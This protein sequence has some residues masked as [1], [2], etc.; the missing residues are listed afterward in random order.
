MRSANAYAANTFIEEPIQGSTEDIPSNETRHCAAWDQPKKVR[1]GRSSPS[2]ITV[3]VGGTV[4]SGG[5][6]SASHCARH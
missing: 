3:G 5:G 6:T 2:R 1:G 4:S